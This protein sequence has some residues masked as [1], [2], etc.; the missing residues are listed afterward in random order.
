MDEEIALA[1]AAWS[2]VTDLVFRQVS[3]KADITVS[4]F[5]GHH[6][7]GNPFDGRGGCLGDASKLIEG[8]VHFD[9]DEA[10]TIRHFSGNEI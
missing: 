7:D 10:W 8:A 9:D 4:F 1:F 2:G 6:R 3:E 5:R